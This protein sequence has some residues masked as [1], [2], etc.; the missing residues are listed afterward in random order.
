MEKTNTP[1]YNTKYLQD[2][3]SF[4]L[5]AV[6]DLKRTFK[7]TEDEVYTLPQN[8]KLA[9]DPATKKMTSFT[10]AELDDNIEAL[11]DEKV[12]EDYAFGEVPNI[13]RFFEFLSKDIRKHK[14]DI[15][16]MVQ[17]K[18]LTDVPSYHKLM[19]IDEQ[20]SILAKMLNK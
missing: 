8:N 20:L 11:E 15:R 2:Y 10:K 13:Q 12:E 16:V 18:S 14:E 17:N 19:E 3:K 7:P 6:K 9:F 4:D 5:K 1:N